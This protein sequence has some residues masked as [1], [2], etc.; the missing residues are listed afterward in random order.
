M[1]DRAA[2][3]SAAIRIPEDRLAPIDAVLGCAESDP[4]LRLSDPKRGIDKRA[5][6]E[7]EALIALRLAGESAAFDW[8]VDAMASGQAV[9][10]L[11]P[12]LFAPVAKAPDAVPTSGRTVCSCFGVSESRIRE[13]VAAGADLERLQSELKC[14]TSCGSCLPELRRIVGAGAAAAAAAAAAGR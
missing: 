14:G 11:R 7:G 1:D 2:P 8:L 5:R 10:P 12:W 4:V 3:A 9:G 6:I 13:A